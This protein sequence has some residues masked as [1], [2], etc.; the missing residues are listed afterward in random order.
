MGDYREPHDQHHDPLMIPSKGLH[1]AIQDAFS[2]PDPFHAPLNDHLHD[3]LSS[4][5]L[6]ESPRLLQQ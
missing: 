2:D 1:D 4:L 5:V 6:K 3:P